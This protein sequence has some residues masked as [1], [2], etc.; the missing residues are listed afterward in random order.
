MASH[1]S[2]QGFTYLWV[3]FA[4]AILSVGLCA[5]GDHSV[6]TAERQKRIELEWIGGQYVRAIGS[7]Y[8]ASPGNR[9]TY[10]PTLEALLLDTRFVYVRR[11]LRRVYADPYTRRSDWQLLRAPDG[12]VMGIS[13]TADGPLNAQSRQFVYLPQGI[14]VMTAPTSTSQ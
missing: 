3:M 10:P 4:V 14:S 7:Y 12:G 11:H 8:E 13:S 5:V 2:D 6:G 1:R 9:K